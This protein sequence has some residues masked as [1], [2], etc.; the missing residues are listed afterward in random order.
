ME[1]ADSLG[2]LPARCSGEEDIAEDERIPKG[3]ACADLGCVCLEGGHEL[4]VNLEV[5]RVLR[6]Q[7]VTPTRKQKQIK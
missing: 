1:A 2:R 7:P 6:W 4:V 3:P 5:R